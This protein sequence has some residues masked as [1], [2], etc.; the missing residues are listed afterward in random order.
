MPGLGCTSIQHTVVR[1]ALADQWPKP[2]TEVVSRD[3]VGIMM[4]SIAGQN[5]G[6][7]TGWRYGAFT[8]IELLVVIA[9]IAI[10]AAMLLP[11][12]SRAKAKAKQTSCLSNLR[13][14]GIAT[15]VYTTEYRAYPGCEWLGGGGFYYVWPTRLLSSMGNNR[16]AFY[17]PSADIS[18]SWD[19]VNNKTLGA[20]SP[21]GVFDP[22]GISG[23]SLFSYAY[24]NWGL[25]I[26]NNPQLGLGGDINGPLYKGLVKDI[27]VKSASEMIMVADAKVGGDGATFP[28]AAPYHDGSLDPTEQAQW[29]SNR[30]SRRT[31]ILF[32]DGHVESA[33]RREVIDPA[34]GSKWRSRWNNDNQPHNEVTWSVNAANE[35]QLDR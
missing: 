12:L 13:Q 4:C 10:L 19:T 24:N 9:I 5:T 6:P 18:S 33:R 11:A 31:V 3:S 25:N 14:I 32:A 2:R 15:T 27:G 1:K 17:C 35:N 8:L 23:N 22:Y 7:R 21:E 28:G 29:P 26:A 34:T 20:M 16:K 30:H